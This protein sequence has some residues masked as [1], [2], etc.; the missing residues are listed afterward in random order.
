[1]PSISSISPTQ[2]SATDD[3]RQ[4][5]QALMKSA[6]D[7]AAKS[8]NMD[9]GD[10]RTQLQSGTSLKDI[11]AAKGVDFS[12]VQSAM[13]DA[14]KPQLDQAVSSGQMTSTQ[15]TDVLNRVTSGDPPKRHHHHGGGGGPPPAASADPST[16]IQQTIDAAAQALKMDPS[17]L[18]DQLKAGNSLKDLASAS[19]IDFSRVQSAISDAR[20]GSTYSAGGASTTSS[21]GAVVDAAA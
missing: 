15:A 6:T 13:S 16:T 7:A 5:M 3:A 19:G 4:K 17:Q 1:M 11:A 10:L 8:L 21:T 9:P 12:K 20:N 2:V 18:L 14:V